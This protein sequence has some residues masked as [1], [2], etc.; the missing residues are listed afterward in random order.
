MASKN[1]MTIPLGL[2]TMRINR[3]LTAKDTRALI[4]KFYQGCR[5]IAEMKIRLQGNGGMDLVA[6]AMAT[7]PSFDWMIK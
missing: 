2:R 4:K 3:S 1:I 5:T 7:D 6:E